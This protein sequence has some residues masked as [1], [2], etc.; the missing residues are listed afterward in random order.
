MAV[1]RHQEW[2]LGRLCLET[3]LSSQNGGFGSPAGKVSFTKGPPFIWKSW[4]V[5]EEICPWE[6]SGQQWVNV[7]SAP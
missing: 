3:E 4:L 2:G 5:S 6:R 7:H 1:Q